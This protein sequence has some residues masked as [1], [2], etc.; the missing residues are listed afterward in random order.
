MI[1]IRTCELVRCDSGN[2]GLV[3]SG[4]CRDDNAG[5]VGCGVGVDVGVGV[6]VGVGVRVFFQFRRRP[7]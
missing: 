4:W 7:W 6:G 3:L 2:F 5:L 1:I